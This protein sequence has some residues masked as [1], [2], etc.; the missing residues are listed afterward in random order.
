VAL[1]PASAEPLPAPETP[2]WTRSQGAESPDDLTVAPEPLDEHDLVG[3]ATAA[4]AGVEIDLTDAADVQHADAREAAA[5]PAEASDPAPWWQQIRSQDDEPD[6]P[7]IDL[8]EEVA[9]LSDE[10]EDVLA[11]LARLR[12]AGLLTPAEFEDERRAMLG[13]GRS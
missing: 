6:I 12:D 11:R 4:P 2:W 5:A 13:T 9:P 7:E 3:E 10:P 1:D 8:R